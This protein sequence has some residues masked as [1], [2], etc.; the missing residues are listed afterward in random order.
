MVNRYRRINENV[1]AIQYTGRNKSE[2]L[3][4]AGSNVK[5]S[6]DHESIMA[7]TPLGNIYVLKDDWVVLKPDGTTHIMRN[8]EFHEIPDTAK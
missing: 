5:I 2:I 6:Q 8:D 3:D 1:S 7:T 4:L